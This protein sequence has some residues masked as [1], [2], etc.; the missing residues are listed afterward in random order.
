MR[1]KIVLLISCA[2]VLVAAA[3][4]FAQ[5]QRQQ[6]FQQPRFQQHFQQPRFQQHFQLHFQQPHFQQHF[7]GGY[8]GGYYGGYGGGYVVEQP[9]QPYCYDTNSGA[10]LHWGYCTGD[11]YG[12]G[13]GQE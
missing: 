12:W 11:D 8:G 7:R 13:E 6:H 5:R 4:A 9:A 10:F 3:P 1:S 2:L